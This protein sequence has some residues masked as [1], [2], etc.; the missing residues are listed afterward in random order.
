MELLVND[1]SLHGQF[2]DLGSF[3][4]AIERVMEIR[5]SAQG[6]SRVLY[7]HRNLAQARVT[8]KMT[9]PQAVQG[10]GSD[11]RRALMQWFTRHGPFWEDTRKHPPGDW[12]EWKGEVVTDTAVG[13][14]G[15]CCLNGIE[16]ALVSFIPSDWEFSPVSVAW[17]SETSGTRTVDIGNYW[18]P[19]SSVESAL[20]DASAPLA[21]WRGL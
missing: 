4:D 21:S 14:A 18:T 17:I 5:R 2:A 7:C 15:W 16:R 13:E 8:P 1:R 6:F 20:R 12:L 3:R 10:L 19:E 11:E 9:M